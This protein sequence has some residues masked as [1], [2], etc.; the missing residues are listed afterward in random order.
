MCR[1]CQQ[2][3]QYWHKKPQWA[4][5]SSQQGYFTTMTEDLGALGTS[6]EHN[7][8]L[9]YIA[10]IQRVTCYTPRPA[11]SESPATS[12][13]TRRLSTDLVNFHVLPNVA[14]SSSPPGKRWDTYCVAI[15][16]Q[17]CCVYS[18]SRASCKWRDSPRIIPALA[19][20]AAPLRGPKLT[21]GLAVEA[22]KNKQTTPCD[23]LSYITKFEYFVAF[24]Q[25]VSTHEMI[26]YNPDPNPKA[27]G[28]PPEGSQSDVRTFLSVHSF[29]FYI[30]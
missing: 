6:Y 21:S 10:H 2:R 19:W 11:L 29:N 23:H 26:N 15:H 17:A 7:T 30:Y 13:P 18:D 9:C 3:V 14:R 24:C 5:T 4:Q 27:T 20:S 12:W 22:G 25:S 16:C 8:D 1:R 28:S